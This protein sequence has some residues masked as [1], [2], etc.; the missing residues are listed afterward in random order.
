MKMIKTVCIIGLGYIGLPTAVMFAN[1]GYN[2]VGIDKDKEIIDNL[3]KG[4]VVIKEPKLDELVKEAIDKKMIKGLYTP[5]KADIFIICVP[6]PITKEKKADLSYI[7][8]AVYDILPYIKNGDIVILESTVPVGTTMNVV[9]SILENRDLDIGKDIYLGYSPERVLPGKI[10]EELTWNHR[11]VG[12]INEISALK[13]KEIY[14]IFV[15]GKIYITDSNTAE[16]VKLAENT[17]RDVNI[18]FANEISQ[19]C[20]SLNINAWNVIEYANKHPRVNILNPGPG[21][22]GHCLAVDPWFIVE[23]SNELAN[24]T[25]LSREINDNIPK[26]IFD[27]VQQLTNEIQDRKKVCILGATYKKDIDDMRGSPIIYL[28]DILRANNYEVSL[29]DP[30]IKI[31]D[32]L[33]EDVLEAAKDSDL[34]LL[35]VDH[36]L[37]KELDY[38]SI[39]NVMNNNIFVDTRKFLDNKSM[40]LIGY[41]YYLIY[42]D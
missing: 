27:K 35:A 10:I 23:S 41:R 38:E 34:I 20:S 29:Y 16:M 25:S 22:G 37:F 31:Y 4:K 30:Y 33:K 8:N 5:C 7:I 13:I 1:N 12:G 32:G 36:T 42:R 39:L 14:E 3:N 19:I 26:Y 6:T 17:F 28:I 40:K 24:I 9:K 11:I 21:V 2:V 15:K 18:A